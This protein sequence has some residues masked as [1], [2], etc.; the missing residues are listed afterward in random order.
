MP[1]LRNRDLSDEQNDKL[2]AAVKE[3]LCTLVPK[4]LHLSKLLAVSQGNLSNFLDGRKGG[5]A[6]T[7]AKRLAA[8]INGAK[9]GRPAKAVAASA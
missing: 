9:G 3:Q 2:R 7:A 1:K 6:K 8:K 4:Q 5:S